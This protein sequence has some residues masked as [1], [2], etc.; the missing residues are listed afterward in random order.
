MNATSTNKTLKQTIDDGAKRIFTVIK[1]FQ[2]M[3]D[4]TILSC[5]LQVTI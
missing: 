2:S 5:W 1:I 4:K 3:D